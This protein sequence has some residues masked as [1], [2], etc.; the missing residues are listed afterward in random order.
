MWQQLLWWSCRPF[1]AGVIWQGEALQTVFCGW[2]FSIKNLI[3]L[4][5]LKDTLEHIIQFILAS[6]RGCINFSGMADLAA[7]FGCSYQ[8]GHCVINL[9][10][11]RHFWTCW[12]QVHFQPLIVCLFLVFHIFHISVKTW[13][14]IFVALFLLFN[15]LLKIVVVVVAKSCFCSCTAAKKRG[16]TFSY[17]QRIIFYPFR[18]TIYAIISILWWFHHYM[19]KHFG[20]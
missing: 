17:S 6:Q 10:G 3:P 9:S 5:Q 1:D 19:L 20:S 12:T 11:A 4:I 13:P 14:R 8:L 2:A 15:L 7:Y 16:D 18:L